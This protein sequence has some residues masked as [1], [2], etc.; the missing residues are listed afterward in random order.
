MCAL[1]K[2]NHI[3]RKHD[4]KIEKMNET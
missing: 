4:E 3:L 1:V 2:K